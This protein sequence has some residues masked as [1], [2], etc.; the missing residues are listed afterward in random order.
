VEPITHG[1]ERGANELSGHERTHCHDL[2]NQALE[3][4][5]KKGAV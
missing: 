3:Y 5:E 2:I 1:F 4:I